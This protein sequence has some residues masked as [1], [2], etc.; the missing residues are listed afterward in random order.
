MGAAGTTFGFAMHVYSVI[1]GATEN[2]RFLL[3]Q[4]PTL[5]IQHTKLKVE[6]FITDLYPGPQIHSVTN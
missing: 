5:D 1:V 6:G 4:G 3:K 2:A